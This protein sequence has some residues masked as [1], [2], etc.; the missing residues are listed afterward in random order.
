LGSDPIADITQEESKALFGAVQVLTNDILTWVS[1]LRWQLALPHIQVGLWQKITG[2]LPI[3]TIPFKQVVG[4]DMHDSMPSGEH[5]VVLKQLLSEIEMTFHAH[6]V[7]E[8]R[9]EKGLATV[10][11]LWVGK[12]S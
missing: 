7:N 10:D 9:R 8:A 11:G 2:Q 3:K 1:P 6:L 5:S 4:C 12:A